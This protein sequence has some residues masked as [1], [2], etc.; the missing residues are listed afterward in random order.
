[1]WSSLLEHQG[2]VGT[3]HSQPGQ[4]ESREG[5]G[6]AGV[7]PARPSAPVFEQQLCRDLWDVQGPGHPLWGHAVL[8]GRLCPG[9]GLAVSTVSSSAELTSA[10]TSN[11]M[12]FPGSSPISQLSTS[13]LAAQRTADEVPAD[14]ECAVVPQGFSQ[15][16]LPALDQG[17][18]LRGLCPRSHPWGMRLPSAVTSVPAHVPDPGRQELAPRP[19]TAHKCCQPCRMP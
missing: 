7:P 2:A 19:L 3:G 14:E 17:G 8:K 12:L 13:E 5:C 1:M 15:A 4:G 11:P 18:C 10:F 16:L 6:H 9:A